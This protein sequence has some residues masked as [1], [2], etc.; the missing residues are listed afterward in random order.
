M[1]THSS[2]DLIRSVLAVLFISILIAA[3]FWILLPFLT[4]LVWATMIV[5]TTWPLMLGLEKLLFGKRAVA[6]TVMTLALLL[7]LVVPLTMSIIS[8]A[9]RADEIVAWTKSLATREIPPPPDW[10]AALPV[11][12]SKISAQWLHLATA[13]K[14]E[15]MTRIEPHLAWIA[16]GER[17]G[18]H[19]AGGGPGRVDEV[20]LQML[21]ELP[22]VP[23]GDA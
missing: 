4:A 5:I 3:S 20:A 15:L 22:P 21:Q 16:L 23:R 10:V 12:G 13:G 19:H 1:N 11:V 7:L 2:P 17:E 9:D 8:I 18:C 6:V 14:A